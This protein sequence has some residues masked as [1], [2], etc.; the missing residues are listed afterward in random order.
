MDQLVVGCVQGRIRL[1]QNLTELEQ[2][3][4]RFVRMA[5]SKRVRLLVFP[6]FTGLMTSALLTLGTRTALLKQADQARRSN[7]SFW[8]RA[9]ARLA[10]SAATALGADFS[11]VLADALEKQPDLVWD[12]YAALF[13]DIARRYAMTLVAGSGY[14]VDPD[15]GA[16]RHMSL[17]FGPDGTLLGQQGAVSLTTNEHPAVQPG[18][19]WQAIQ[20]PAGRLGILIGDDMLYP[21]SGRLLAYAGAEILVG[22]GASTIATSAL[23]QRQ[24]LLARVEENQLYGLMSFAVGYNPFTR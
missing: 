15:D 3:L 21:E 12:S 5:Q 7:V 10:G 6:Q 17:V 18:R 19:R 1:P 16:V 14:L 20:T 24:G 11:R 4:M 22:M 8:T 9:R 13:S 2:H 23:R